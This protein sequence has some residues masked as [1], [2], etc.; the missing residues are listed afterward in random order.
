MII[1]T[2]DL[3]KL[4]LR[5]AESEDLSLG[6]TKLIKLL[7]LLEVEYYR[8]HQKRLTNLTW[9]FYH[10]GPYP[11]EIE[12]ILGSPDLE[13]IPQFLQGGKVYKRYSVVSDRSIEASPDP[14]IRNLISTVVKEWAGLDLYDL[15]DYVYFET[16]PMMQAK[17][18]DALDFTTIPPW[19]ETKPRDIKLDKKKLAEIKQGIKEH[20][21]NLSRPEL[22]FTIDK[23][24]SE[25]I[26]IWDEG[27]TTVL[28]RGETVVDPECFNPGETD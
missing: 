1:E 24:L 19:Q 22:R 3:L 5:E 13:E 6:K 9:Q 14:K 17:R 4:I 25:A 18:G 23:D 15:L 26:R 21:K 28:I 7:Y 20:T 2:S 10:Y 11:L 12:P 16:E 8:L 27:K